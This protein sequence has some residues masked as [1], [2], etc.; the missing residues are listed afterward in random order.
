MILD[1]LANIL[2]MAGPAVEV[3]TTQIEEAGGLEKIELLQHHKNQDI[4]ALAYRI[5]DKYF[6]PE[7]RELHCQHMQ[8]RI[9]L[10][11]SHTNTQR[12]STKH[13]ITFTQYIIYVGVTNI[14][15]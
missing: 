7:V 8:Y 2:K 13:N 9:L 5:I 11:G 6:T 15:M 3:I 4:Y 14:N 12:Q 10:E 1:G